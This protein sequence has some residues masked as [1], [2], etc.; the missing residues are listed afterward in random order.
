M[1]PSILIRIKLSRVDVFRRFL[2]VVFMRFID[3]KQRSHSAVLTAMR[4]AIEASLDS[5][6]VRTYHEV[7]CLYKVAWSGFTSHLH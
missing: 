4:A 1:G 6:G 3:E 2:S 7:R 5:W